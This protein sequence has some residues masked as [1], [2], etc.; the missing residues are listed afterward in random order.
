M[1]LLDFGVIALVNKAEFV[2][3]GNTVEAGIEFG[4]LYDFFDG[5]D[6]ITEHGLI[7]RIVDD[8]VDRHSHPFIQLRD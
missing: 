2:G 1:L 3:H 4:C 7:I 5:K 6:S 8:E